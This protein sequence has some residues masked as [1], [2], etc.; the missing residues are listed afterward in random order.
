MNNLKINQMNMSANGVNSANTQLMNNYNNTAAQKLNKQVR[1]WCNWA[2]LQAVSC[3]LS[4]AIA[5]YS[6]I[7]HSYY[8][9]TAKHSVS[10]CKKTI[11]L[12]KIL[13]G[14]TTG[15][16]D[17]FPQQKTAFCLLTLYIR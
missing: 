13:A 10:K 17:Q 1:F 8:K 14:L 15:V 3:G 7:G 5:K 4:A 2:M 16:N 6:N 11:P 9:C 12:S